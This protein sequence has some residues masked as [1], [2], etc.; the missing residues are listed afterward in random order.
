M[1]KEFFEIVHSCRVSFQNEKT[2]I[3]YK[4]ETSSKNTSQILL[5]NCS[6]NNA[7]LLIYL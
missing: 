2:A 1:V 5:F 7:S 6:F 4:G 3:F